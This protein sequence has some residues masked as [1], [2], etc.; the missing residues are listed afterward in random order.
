MSS[1]SV[2]SS[3]TS[4]SDYLADPPPRIKRIK[5]ELLQKLNYLRLSSSAFMIAAVVAVVV[6]GILIGLSQ[7]SYVPPES[8]LYAFGATVPLIL[9]TVALDRTLRCLAYKNNIDPAD[10][11]RIYQPKDPKPKDPKAKKTS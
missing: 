1:R 11:F 8:P 2:S 3:S 5:P 9:I 6:G 10:Y 7:A 4:S